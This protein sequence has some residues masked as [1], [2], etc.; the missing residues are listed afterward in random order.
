[1]TG[2]LFKLRSLHK[3]KKGVDLFWY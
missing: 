3:Q 2:F 1:M